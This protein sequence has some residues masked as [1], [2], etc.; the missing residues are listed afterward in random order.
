MFHSSHL[1]VGEKMWYIITKILTIS[2]SD[3]HPFAVLTKERHLI[4]LR[5]TICTFLVE[6]HGQLYSFLRDKFSFMKQC[7]TRGKHL[8]PTFGFERE[9]KKVFIVSMCMKRKRLIHVLGTREDS[10]SCCA[11][12]T[13]SPSHETYLYRTLAVRR[14]FHYVRLFLSCWFMIPLRSGRTRSKS[15]RFMRRLVLSALNVVLTGIEKN[16]AS[17]LSSDTSGKWPL[18]C[19]SSVLLSIVGPM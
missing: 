14:F 6:C 17:N 4:L 3:G 18:I 16:T 13:F 1:S 5:T 9:S 19:H 10:L 2:L 12:K 15:W 8:D 11:W 7:S